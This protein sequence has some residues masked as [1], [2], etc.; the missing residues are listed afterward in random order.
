MNAPIPTSAPEVMDRFHEE[1]EIDLRQYIGIV[2]RHKWGIVS[3]VMVISLLALL[4]LY[5]RQPVFQ[6]KATL[7]LESESANVVSIEEVYG[8]ASA[9]KEY[10]QTQYEI[11]ASRAIAQRVIDQLNLRE[12]PDFSLEKKPF[13]GIDWAGMLPGSSDEPKKLEIS[14]SN[15]R[16][17]LFE[18][19]SS[20]LQ[21]S[22]VTNS[23]LVNILYDSFDPEL[24]AKVAN[25]VGEA[26]INSMLEG[27]LEMT[28]KASQWLTQRLEK[29]RIKLE[30]SE[31]KL[32]AFI[33]KEKL[34]D[35]QG[36]KSLTAKRLDEITNKLVEARRKRAEAETLYRQ[37][38]QARKQGGSR[39][40]SLPAVLSHPT[41]QTMKQEVSGAERKIN[42]L[43]KR[44]GP[45]HP[46]MIQAQSELRASQRSLSRQIQNV[47]S[48]V[49]KE[50]EVA[51]ANQV[52]LEREMS[53]SKDEVQ[54][55]N[56]KRYELSVLQREVEANR[57][58]YDL[59]LTR[60]KETSESSGMGTANAR[61]IDPAVVPSG[62]YK[63]N[64]QR[65]MFMVILLSGL[66]G[67]ALAFVYEHLDNTVKGSAELEEKVGLPVLG[68]LP[69]L[70]TKGKRDKSVLRA[71]LDDDQTTFAES[72]RTI[73][74]GVL[75]SSLDDEHKIVLVTSSVPGEGKS[76]TAM[77]L[78]H[79]MS[80]MSKTLLIDADMRR[81]SI[82]EACDLG[83]HPKGLSQYAAGTAN[84]SE[85][86]Y[87]IPGT[88]LHVMPAGIIPPNPLE[89]LSSRKFEVALEKLSE[90][91]DHVV[92]DSA[93]AMAVSDSLVLSR[94]AQ[95]V[96]YVVKADS[97]PLPVVK[98]GVKRLANVN[99]N[100]I[101]AVLNMPAGS[102]SGGYGYYGGD[103]YSDYT[104]S[105]S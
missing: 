8:L 22:P 68:M 86:V 81:P 45:K 5:S 36:F 75:L 40:D 88:K 104:Y 87:D 76:T 72:V 59:F 92:I 91:F 100:L 39:L 26:Y 83:H 102:R 23:Q 74:T 48:G 10:F 62:P 73:R 49:E 43:S 41:V 93:P 15:L 64:K 14:E 1:D 12:H 37:V 29:L 69:K 27:R 98:T 21:I 90:V 80:H 94:H 77:N 53:A 6:G 95:A 42:E 52:S 28:Q 2:N 54:D 97:T 25:A 79:A 63:P 20:R 96:I 9:N 33:E 44:Y 82:A 61:L 50:Y 89:L 11:L 3:F 13:L 32:Q 19:F 71:F 38:Q 24:S 35:V 99:A 17:I 70:K 101:G 56:K 84:I 16:N 47:L 30:E 34:V 105:K 58:L 7:L 18:R 51:R 78:A 85:A 31:K 65:I 57:N 46:K 55:I 67:I 66:G 103:Y 4:M 60:F